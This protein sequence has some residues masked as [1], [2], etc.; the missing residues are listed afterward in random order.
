MRIRREEYRAPRA[1]GRVIARVQV[2][3]GGSPRSPYPRFIF[4][5]EISEP[6]PISIFSKSF[7]LFKE[8]SRLFDPEFFC[9]VSYFRVISTPAIRRDSGEC[10]SGEFG[11]GFSGIETAVARAKDEI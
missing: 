4:L 7:Y 3:Q 1:L 2:S 6:A 5:M 11:E 8:E 10:I 9:S